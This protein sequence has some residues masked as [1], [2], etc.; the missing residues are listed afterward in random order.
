MNSLT[1]DDVHFIYTVLLSAKS[2]LDSISCMTVHCS[3]NDYIY[4]YSLKLY[5]FIQSGGGCSS[6]VLEPLS[7]SSAVLPSGITL[8]LRNA[9]HVYS[10]NRTV[11]GESVIVN[12]ND[13]NSCKLFI[14][15]L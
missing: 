13:L 1:G 2:L 10:C 9:T 3:T 11:D 6:M 7:N 8:N 12:G 14:I 4:S 15:A 5:F